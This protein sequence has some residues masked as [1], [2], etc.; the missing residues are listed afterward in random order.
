MLV[1]LSEWTLMWLG[2]LDTIGAT[3]DVTMLHLVLWIPILGCFM[4]PLARGSAH[5]NLSR[6]K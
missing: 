4:C 5:T 6:E 3:D 2:P 1:L